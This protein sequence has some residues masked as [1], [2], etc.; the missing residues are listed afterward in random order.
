MSASEQRSAAHTPGLF[1]ADAHPFDPLRVITDGLG[2]I[3][4]GQGADR[5]GVRMIRPLSDA[6]GQPIMNGRRGEQ[7]RAILAGVFGRADLWRAAEQIAE[8]NARPADDSRDSLGIAGAVGRCHTYAH[9]QR[10]G[11]PI[12]GQ[13]LPG[14]LGTVRTEGIH[15]F[16]TLVADIDPKPGAASAAPGVALAVTCDLATVLVEVGVPRR[17][18]MIMQS[19]RG[20]YAQIAIEPQ[21]L[22]A[23]PVMQLATR[24]LARLIEAAGEPV[25]GDEAVFDAARILRVPG[26][27]NWKPDADPMTPAWI[28]EPW[29]P[30][31]R[32]PWS[33][34]EKLAAKSRPKLRVVPSGGSVPRSSDRRPLL[35]LLRDRGM[36]YGI[37]TDGVVDVR[38]PNADQHSDNRPGA[39]LYPPTTPG[40]PGWLKCS[41]A[42]CAHLTLFDFFRLLER[43]A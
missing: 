13:L 26:T 43:G 11:A 9:A 34:V 2:L 42:H 18:I 24:T 19:G 15:T 10:V 7:C 38:C 22:T 3:A 1:Y 28:L 39:I 17:A 4:D 35:D 14:R 6:N 41:H 31:V 23:R 30:G 37:R 29:T 40:G 16:T 20:A 25:I 27:I 33:V 12:T 8:L 21:P 36:V 32:T 5:V